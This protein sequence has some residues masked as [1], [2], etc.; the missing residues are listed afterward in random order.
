MQYLKFV[1]PNY[2]NYLKFFGI[3]RQ[4]NIRIQNYMINCQKITRC[5]FGIR[6][7]YFKKKASY[8][9]E[10]LENSVSKNNY[11]K[12]KDIYLILKQ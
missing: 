7:I 8:I 11:L 1:H 6:G 5:L 12:I 4:V 10:K 3:L 9:K 2:L